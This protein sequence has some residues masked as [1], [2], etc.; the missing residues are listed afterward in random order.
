[1]ALAI[2]VTNGRGLSNETR[3]LLKMSKVKTASKSNINVH[4][5]NRHVFAH[6]IMPFGTIPSFWI[7]WIISRLDP[8]LWFSL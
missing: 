4:V 7:N 8:K 5:H 1:M 2:D 6:I 3:R